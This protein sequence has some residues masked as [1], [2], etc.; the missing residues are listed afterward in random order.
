VAVFLGTALLGES[1]TVPILLGA[2]LV[3]SGSALAQVK[4]RKRSG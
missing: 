4:L 2:S 1:L 3:I